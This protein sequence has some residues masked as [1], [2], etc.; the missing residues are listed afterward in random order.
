M[1]RD[2]GGCSQ[3]ADGEADAPLAKELHIAMVVPVYEVEQ[4]GIF[5]NTAAMIAND[6]SIWASIARHIFRMC[7]GFLGEV[8]FPAGESGVSG[9]RP[10]I[11]QGRHLYML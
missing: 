6:G 1:V 11:R 4:E 3:W 2:D 7:A 8:L 10:G 9:F 5:Y